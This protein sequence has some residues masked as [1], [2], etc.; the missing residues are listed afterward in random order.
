[1]TNENDHFIADYVRRQSPL[2]LIEFEANGRIVSAGDY[3]GQL[4]GKDLI[5]HSFREIF[6]NVPEDRAFSSWCPTGEKESLLDILL[7][8]GTPQTWMW[9][10]R[11]DSQ[12]TLALGRPD[13]SGGEAMQK[14]LLSLNAELSTLTRKLHQS[15]AK[16]ERLDALK[17]RF[18]RM[19]AHDLRTPLAAVSTYSDLLHEDLKA[20][21]SA[22]HLEFIDGIRESSRFMLNLVTNLLDVSRIES[23]KLVL[24][25]APSDLSELI[26]GT[27][28]LNQLLADRKN[29]VLRRKEPSTQIPLVEVDQ[30]RIEQVIN[31]LLSNAIK[32][33]KPGSEVVIDSECTASEVQIR[34]SD[35]A[36]GIPEEE[37]PKLFQPFQCVRRHGTEGEPGTGLGLS[38]AEN[39]MKAHGGSITVESTLGTGSVFTLKFPV[40]V[41]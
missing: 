22:E 28:R 17:S 39:I 3:L 38:I 30:A 29:I 1:M 11:G 8:D 6:C 35:Q 9:L 4:F 31:N 15:N 24:E 18:L 12:R 7:P 5:G 25:P 20:T 36:G 10:F 37:L 21:L 2:L 14:H 32:F 19:A 23:G 13:I 41:P 26:R 33:S 16:L 40:P 34:V 27:V